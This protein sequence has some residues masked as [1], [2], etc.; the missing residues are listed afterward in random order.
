[1]SRITCFKRDFF[2]LKNCT[3]VVFFLTNFNS[4]NV[5][6]VTDMLCDTLQMDCW[7]QLFDNKNSALFKNSMLVTKPGNWLCNQCK[8]LYNLVSQ[9]MTSLQPDLPLSQINT[10]AGRMKLKLEVCTFFVTDSSLCSS[11]SQID[12]KRGKRNKKSLL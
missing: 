11:N 3:C 4:D 1:M 2:C 10:S 9:R 6:Q 5:C 8:H 12:Q 7:L